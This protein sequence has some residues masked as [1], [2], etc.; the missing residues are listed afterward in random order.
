M[1]F[2][3]EHAGKREYPCKMFSLKN[4]I[5]KNSIITMEISSLEQLLDK[6]QCGNISMVG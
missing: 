2:P 4:V 1:N 5:E 6:T 3:H